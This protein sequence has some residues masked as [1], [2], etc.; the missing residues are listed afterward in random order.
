MLLRCLGGLEVEGSGFRRQK[1]LL[2]LAYLAVEGPA[3][4]RS[5][6]RLF[7][8][9][10][11][12]AMKALGMTVT[13]LRQGLPGC[14]DADGVSARA[15]VSC[16]VAAF[17]AAIADGDLA[18]ARSL[19]RGSFLDGVQLHGC[20]SE[21][22]EWLFATRE[23]LAA[24]MRRLERSQLDLGAELR[25]STAQERSAAA[26]RPRPLPALPAGRV[27]R[28]SEERAVVAALK[29]TRLVT[30][31]GMAG[32]GK[33]HLALSLA[34]RAASHERRAGSGS[35]A[36][37][38]GRFEAGVAFVPL[39]AVLHPEF[40]AGAVV[41]SLG[42]E[43]S[44][45]RSAADLIA[46]SLGDE[47]FLL[48]LDNVEHLRGL[49]AF[50]ASLL[51]A[52]PGL[53][54]LLTSRSRLQL[55]GAAT[56]AL[57]GLSVPPASAEP[58]TLRR[59]PALRL[60]VERARRTSPGFE[61]DDDAIRSVA[62]VCR[63]LEGL[64]L[65]IELAAPW[66]RLMDPAELA[67]AAASEW[68]ALAGDAPAGRHA[69]LL[70]ALEYGWSLLEVGARK[71]LMRLSVFRGGFDLSAAAAVAGADLGTLAALADASMVRRDE[72]GRFSQ[73]PL[74][75]EFGEEKLRTSGD[76]LAVGG[77]HA[78]WY[79]GAGTTTAAAPA[80][81]ENLTAAWSFAARTEHLDLLAAGVPLLERA[82]GRQPQELATLLAAG[83][84]AVAKIRAERD[85]AADPAARVE[86]RTAA[87]PLAKV[88]APNDATSTIDALELRLR[89]ALTAPQMSTLGYASPEVE[90]N[91][92]L[93]QALSPAAGEPGDSFAVLWGLWGL[94]VVRGAI[95]TASRLASDCTKVA[96][97]SGQ[98]WLVV[99]GE[100]MVAE[101]DLWGGRVRQA[102]KRYLSA[103]QALQSPLS[104]HDLP[105][106]LDGHHPAVTMHSMLALS[107]WCLGDPSEAY[108]ASDEALRL[109]EGVGHPYG[110]AYATT[111]A[112]VLG[113][114]ERDHARTLR[115][116]I[117][118]EAVSREHGFQH[119]AAVGR[120]LQGWVA[121]REGDL[122]VGSCDLE[123]GLA[124]WR[125]TGAGHSLPF[126]LALLAESQSLRGLNHE[127]MGTLDGALAL[128]DA[129]GERWWESEL[130][131][132][133]GLVRA[134]LGDLV[135]AEADLRRAVT[136]AGRRGAEGWRARAEESRARLAL[137]PRLPSNAAT[138]DSTA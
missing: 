86:Q 48:V 22:E 20:G 42:W 137:G 114:M 54:L 18:A 52:A 110:V 5:L 112:A 59:S 72:H 63:S 88:T 103:L 126:F 94:H 12:D 10:S 100:R 80:D 121:C 115:L 85:A 13:R 53:H 17:E 98:P 15:N 102:R 119:W 31:T 82:L 134:A 47:R 64:P 116:A 97:R 45:D 75:K 32:A 89:L 65:A 4:R 68:R 66:V 120:L 92:A 35:T 51:T 6:A 107:H 79:L 74:L 9:H 43:P 123:G 58:P 95:D 2:L 113:C 83:L 30:I 101:A 55:A 26:L 90:A 133:R 14:I 76:S 44:P 78:A 131:R 118:G 16:D 46:A 33:S 25:G 132:W 71:P 29:R 24:A 19:Y 105:A 67:L 39:E 124:D 70:A 21:V 73:H 61:L 125:A 111:L 69:N 56:V 11:G 96:R 127:A 135:S 36:S 41:R 104:A 37:L 1:A 40:V 91:L 7:M 3:Y 129:Q 93:A 49:E 81:N 99:E 87:K 122:G 38:A 23:R 34:H 77:R 28:P 138:S 128:V 117:A 84:D 130:F 60:F 108:A 109:A 136:V 8:P 57:T 106:F 27:A 50:L 62:A